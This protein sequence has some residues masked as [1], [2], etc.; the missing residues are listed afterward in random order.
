MQDRIFCVAPQYGN[1]GKAQFQIL[2]T[3]SIKAAINPQDF[4]AFQIPGLNIKRVGWVDGGL[5]P[6]HSD[7]NK[8]SSELTLCLARL[9][10][11]L[12]GLLA[13]IL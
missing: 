3:D 2:S 6:F 4:Y 7:S 10:A 5:C 13:A 11:S 12:V 9:N 1:T 8:G